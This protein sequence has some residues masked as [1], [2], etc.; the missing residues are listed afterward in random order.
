MKKAAVLTACIL[1]GFCVLATAGCGNVDVRPECEVT[2]FGESGEI[3]RSFS[4]RRGDEI[5]AP[6]AEERAGYVISWT[7]GEGRKTAFPRSATESAEYYLVYERDDG[8]VEC[9][10]EIYLQRAD[11]SYGDAPDRTETT[12]CLPGFDLECVPKSIEG[13]VFD[14]GHSGNV[15]K[16]TDKP[17]ISP[18][19]KAYYALNK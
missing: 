3:L 18:V 5:Q 11:G 8:K 4:V 1:I 7:D 9:T 15:L 10:L 13:Y 2:F 16:I 14:A 17:G 19:F 12:L 6:Y